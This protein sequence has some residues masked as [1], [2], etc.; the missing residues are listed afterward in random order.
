MNPFSTVKEVHAPHGGELASTL[1]HVDYQLDGALA[2]LIDNSIDAD[3]KDVLIR[4]QRRG[5]YP[6][7]ILVIDDGDGIKKQDFKTAM[8]WA[9]RRKYDTDDTGMFGVGMKSSSLALCEVLT[10]VSK[11]RGSTVNGCRWTRENID[12]E[13]LLEL[14]ATEC[15]QWFQSVRTSVNGHNWLS[16]TMIYWENVD[17][18]EVARASKESPAKFL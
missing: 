10:V 13:V 3:A 1:T 11:A 15:D 8:T 7:S 16:G 18:F 4:I 2:E 6:V 5:Q 12:K 17:E 14:K 9:Q